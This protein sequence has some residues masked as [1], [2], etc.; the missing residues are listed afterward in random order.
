MTTVAIIPARGKSQRIPRK[1]I[2]NFMG[3]PIINYSIEAAKESG[4]FDTVYVS[5]DSP[6]ILNISEDHGAIPLL[7]HE[8]LSDNDTGTYAVT[9]AVAGHLKLKPEDIVCCIYATAP[10]MSVSD[11]QGGYINLLQLDADH[12]ISIGYPP[13][14]DAAQFYWSTVDALQ[15]GIE[16]FDTSTVLIPIKPERVCD[17]NTQD[18]WDRAEQMYSALK[19]NEMLNNRGV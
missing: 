3:K 14:Q 2:K 18:D 9:R 10:L 13:L 1:N 4:L 16:Y 5:S 12:A 7:R 17:I 11:L 6:E 8:S 15:R 19:N